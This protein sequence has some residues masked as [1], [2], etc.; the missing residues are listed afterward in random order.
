MVYVNQLSYVQTTM[1]VKK[2]GICLDVTIIPLLNEYHLS[3]RETRDSRHFNRFEGQ[4]SIVNT[5]KCHNKNYLINY[6]DIC[7][8]LRRS[9]QGNERHL[10]YISTYLSPL[11]I[12]APFSKP[13]LTAISN[14]YS[15]QY[16]LVNIYQLLIKIRSFSTEFT[17]SR[18]T[19]RPFYISNNKQKFK[20]QFLFS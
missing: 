19:L 17:V 16:V 2:I 8:V 1:A 5:A 6:S 12:H 14:T 11:F 4:C 15:C 7:L 20:M 13:Y 9:L 18:F 10:I 3:L